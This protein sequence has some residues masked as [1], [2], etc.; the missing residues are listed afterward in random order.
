MAIMKRERKEPVDLSPRAWA[1]SP[2][3][4]FE[5]MDRL[6]NDLR[7]GLVMPG[8]D[9]LPMEGARVPT[10]DLKEEADRFLVQAELPG[11]TKDDVSI[12]MDDEV[13]VITA[14]KEQ[15][16]EEEEGGYIRRERGCMRFYR[17]LRLPENVDRGGIKAK[18]ENGVL[19]VVLP[20]VKASEEKRSKIEVD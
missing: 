20:K 7:S 1:W 8:Y 11:M 17:Q 14:N 2:V 13:L 5:E 4:M 15:E 16:R 19:E 6:L 12:E 10:L 9:V 3:S 18:M